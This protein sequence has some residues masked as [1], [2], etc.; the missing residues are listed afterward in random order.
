MLEVILEGLLFGLGLAISMG[1]IFIALTQTSIEK[2]VMPGLTVGAGIW[3]SDIIFIVGFYKFIYLIKDKVENSQFELWMGL[4]GSVI[5]I[6]FG[7]YLLFTKTK[8]DFSK[9]KHSYKNY[10][11]FWL[12]GF[13]IN[14]INPF[15]FFF[16]M[17]V[18][19]SYVIGRNIPE[20]ETIV[21]LTTILLVII[22]SDTGK[23]FL[24]SFLKTVLEDKHIQF[25]TNLSG[26]LLL[27]FGVFM[28]YKVL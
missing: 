3:V 7:L 25:V 26:A 24:A 8:L 18:I 22:L 14:T 28:A 1:P 20:Q 11:G 2:G 21:L 27:V 19:S 17:G 12:K 6:A 5:L 4:S 9:V 13:L 10:I 16:W 15:T 23:V